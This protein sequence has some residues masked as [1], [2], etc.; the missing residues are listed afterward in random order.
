MNFTAVYISIYCFFLLNLPLL[1]QETADPSLLTLDRIYSGEF[2]QEYEQQ[3]QWVNDGEGFVTIERSES[4]A[5]ARDLVY[6]RSSDLGKSIFVSAEALST[7]NG[8]LSI[9]SFSLSPDRSKVLIFTN[10]SRV[11]RSNTK[12]DFWIYDLSSQRLQQLGV[13]FPT[14]SLMFAKFSQDNRF[15]CY[16]HQ[17]NIYQEDFRSGEI[18]QLT[19]DGDGGIINGT[20]DW[21]YEEE[22]GKRDG[23]SIS[24]DDEHIAFW[25]LDATDTGVFYMINN[26]DSIYSQPVPVQYP[27]VGELP[28]AAKIGLIDLAGGS[29]KWVPLPGGE[30]DNYIPAMQWVN[31]D[32][33]LI[34][35]MN[36]HQNQLLV[37]GYVPSTGE[38][39]QLYSE[40]ED[41]WVDLAYPDVSANGWGNNDLPIIDEGTAFLR[42][43][44]NDG[45]RHL[46]RVN[47]S[48]G[49]QD[50]LSPGDYDVASLRPATT[51]GVYV[52]ASPDNSTQRYLYQ[53]AYTGQAQPQKITPEE[54]SGLNNYN[55]SPNGQYAIHTHQS[56]DEVRTVRFIR[57]PEH[58]VIK[59]LV[60][61]VDYRQQ[62]AG[63]QLP[64]TRFS[65]VTTEEGIEIDVRMTLPPGFDS[66]QLYP[67]LFHVYGEPWGAVAIDRQIGLWDIFMAQQGYVIIDMDN[68]GTPCL[69]GS[70]WRKSIYRQIGRINVRD[71]AL[72]TQEILK[73]DYLDANRTA[74]WGW[75]GGG[76]MT[77][78]LLF[79][80]PEVYG[81]GI[82]VAPVSNQLIYDN[83]YQ[84]RYMGLP[85]ENREDFIAG[86]P[87]T[88]AKNLEGNLLL[89]HGTADDNVHYQSAELLI[90]ELIRHNK[91]FD[92]MAYPNRSHGIY[93]G[94]NTRR[95]LYTL[96]TNYLLEHT[97]VE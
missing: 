58:E 22:F 2:R 67:V 19:T 24:P 66:E 82:A 44:E 6:Y 89:I 12:G 78:N 55:I 7:E 77:L 53:L 5:P 20:F 73:L 43:T 69:K 51:E 13:D 91:Q 41:T 70:E 39:N 95:H 85:Q 46:Y 8:P 18:R 1:A 79:Q 68:R 88:H 59:T 27:K 23:F 63:L 14:S 75:S 29:I 17:F 54:F 32:L 74:V 52:M 94:E 28:S 76:S 80:Y 47:L 60:Y 10:S 86:S 36:R 35:Q 3:I 49:K 15:V 62:L 16:V 71:Q 30:R 21:V 61:N 34:Q 57:L 83:I 81:T 84:E 33:L 31:E 25:R 11:W 56:V 37:W 93:E 90:N 50:L 38:L 65:Q 26:T 87:V 96:M 9:E 92:M 4:M 45:W 42:L 97:S 64:E 48:S 40:Q 72:A